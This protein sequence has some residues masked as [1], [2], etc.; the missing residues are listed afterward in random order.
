MRQH[1]GHAGR[2]LVEHLL[3]ADL[4]RLGARFEVVRDTYARRFEPGTATR[5][6]AH[7]GAI[8]FAGELALDL[9][10]PCP[11]LAAVEDVLADCIRRGTAD[12]DRPRAALVDLLAWLNAN[13]A[14]VLGRGADDDDGTPS[15]GWLGKV[16]TPDDSRRPRFCIVKTEADA[17]L[18]RMGHRR[19]DVLAAWAQRDWLDGQGRGRTRTVRFSGL[20]VSCYVVPWEIGLAVIHDPSGLGEGDEPPTPTTLVDDWQ[21]HDDET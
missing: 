4:D 16:E 18:D 9:G 21:W 2:A 10:L 5:L 19:E 7:A 17:A 6:A 14:R 12:A 11:N 15:G 13:P 20:P 1:Y 3:A 8:L